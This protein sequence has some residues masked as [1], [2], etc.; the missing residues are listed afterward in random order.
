MKRRA[1]LG[2]YSQ[3]LLHNQ[4]NTI[5][6]K[7]LKFLNF[8]KIK[9]EVAAGKPMTD[10][11]QN[12]FRSNGI[13]SPVVSDTRVT[14]SSDDVTVFL[15]D[16]EATLAPLPYFSVLQAAIIKKLP[17][18]CAD[19][20]P[21]NVALLEELENVSASENI[22]DLQQTL[23][24]A[25]NAQYKDLAANGRLQTVLS[26]HLTQ[27]IT[28]RSKLGYVKRVEADILRELCVGTGFQTTV[29]SD[30]KAFFQTA[31]RPN[32]QTMK[33]KRK[34]CVAIFCNE[35]KEG[36]EAF[37]G[38]TQ[39]G[40][41][42]SHVTAFIDPT[43]AGSMLMPRSYSKIRAHLSELLKANVKLVFITG[44]SSVASAAEASGDVDC[45]FLCLRPCNEWMTIDTFVA[46]NLPQLVSLNQI[47]QPQLPLDF[48]SISAEAVKASG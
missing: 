5:P 28:Q 8:D 38:N 40:D 42:S 7:I 20:V 24:E 45:T 17:N 30:V 36:Q 11:L 10:D 6:D 32:A 12:V 9:E 35:A 16:L 13:V 14:S 47:I 48:A 2:F 27:R 4:T 1:Q 44:N 29:F 21:K 41:L 22:L 3:S 31:G 34:T 43:F 39:C 26:D 25:K 23:E 46:I 33:S 15:M 37:L 18:Y 19:N